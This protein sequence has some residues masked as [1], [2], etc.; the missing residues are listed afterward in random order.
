MK[1]SQIRPKNLVILARA[2][3]E[4][5]LE[6]YLANRSRFIVRACPGCG[7][8]SNEVYM[9]KESFEYA[10]CAGCGS[11]FMNPGP[12]E[13]LINQ[14]YKS[15]KNY[16]F[17]GEFMYPQTRTERLSTI[18]KERANWVVSNLKKRFPNQDTFSILELG[19]GTGDSL[20]TIV[21]FGQEKIIGFAIEPNQS[22]QAHLRENGIQ[23]IQEGDLNAEDF[24]HKFDAVVSFEVLEHLLKP[25]LYLSLF[26]KTLKKGGL[27][28]ATTPNANSIEIQL[29]KSD[30][31]SID[32]EHI[33]VL[34]PAGIQ[35]LSLLNGFRVEEIITP[36]KF[37]VELIREIHKEFSIST[38]HNLNPENSQSLIQAMGFSSHMRCILSLK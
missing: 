6:F 17:W 8:Q 23:V 16:E 25:G 20:A 1:I 38:N 13:E 30:S 32:I 9:Q 14:F 3:Y 26:S 10:R 24:V 7:L 22:M 36:G 4:K 31:T 11:V 28:F 33:S 34:S 29:L 37:D 15:S 5:D 18:H 35:A 27:F 21:Q 12:S 2:A 19:A